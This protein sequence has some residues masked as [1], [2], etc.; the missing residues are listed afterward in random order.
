ML[1]PALRALGLLALVLAAQQVVAAMM[2]PIL[3][4]PCPRRPNFQQLL[5]PLPLVLVLVLSAMPRATR[6]CSRSCRGVTAAPQQEHHRRRHL[7]QQARP[8]PSSR[9][10][11]LQAGPSPLSCSGR[12]RASSPPPTPATGRCT[13]AQLPPLPPLLL[14]HRQLEALELPAV[15]RLRLHLRRRRQPQLS[16]L[17]P[18][19]QASASAAC[20]ACRYPPPSQRAASRQHARCSAPPTARAAVRCSI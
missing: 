14:L 3:S 5:L 11:A 6:R 2:R 19:A 4:A 7:R 10:N 20:A 8:P 15:D 18:L 16:R 17:C 1:T 13:W 9:S 12:R